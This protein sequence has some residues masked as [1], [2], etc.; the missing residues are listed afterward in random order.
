MI[1][2]VTGAKPD[3]SPKVESF[4]SL[5]LASRIDVYLPIT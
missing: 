4:R 5:V 2:Q 3:S 1:G